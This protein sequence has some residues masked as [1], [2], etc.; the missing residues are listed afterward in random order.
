M[1]VIHLIST[2]LTATF[3]SL[4]FLS[5]FALSCKEPVSA[6]D[7][8]APFLTPPGAQVTH[9]GDA[10]QIC[11]CASDTRIAYTTQTVLGGSFVHG[12]IKS[13]DILSRTIQSVDRTLRPINYILAA[14][15][16]VLYDALDPIKGGER[17]YIAAANGTMKSPR[18]VS[19]GSLW[20]F[21][22]DRQ[23][24]LIEGVLPDTA[25]VVKVKDSSVI[26][27]PLQEGSL[28]PWGF[29][30]DDNHLYFR[31]GRLLNITDETWTMGPYPMPPNA[32]S[33][34]WT[35]NGFLAI[36]PSTGSGPDVYT[37]NNLLTGASTI[38]W[39]QTMDDMFTPPFAWSS[40]GKKSAFLRSSRMYASP[41]MEYLYVCVKGRV[42]P[43]FEVQSIPHPLVG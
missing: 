33:A 43:Q 17:I 16:S 21:S 8:S 32:F 31:D 5:L 42:I 26:K 10:N 41:F 13:V 38:I 39:R 35:Q 36:S 34:I 7:T 4:V 28:F 24:I 23:L 25:E 30:P 12:T 6:P 40:D 18:Q 2:E 27:I 14:G 19:F 11:W 9:D 20:G 15:D 29:S 37:I 22:A 3:A 1:K